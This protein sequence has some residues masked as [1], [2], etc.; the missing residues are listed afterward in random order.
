MTDGNLTD[1]M[2]QSAKILWGITF[3]VAIVITAVVTYAIT[4]STSED[5]GDL[6]W[7]A[8]ATVALDQRL[9]LLEERSDNAAA[10]AELAEQI[11]LQAEVVAELAEQLEADKLVAEESVPEVS[12]EKTPSPD[13]VYP[14]IFGS[15][16]EVD[17]LLLPLLFMMALSG[18]VE[19]PY[20]GPSAPDYD[21]GCSCCSDCWY[22]SGDYCDYDIYDDEPYY[23]DYEYEY[24]EYEEPYLPLDDVMSSDYPSPS[25]EDLAFFME[26]LEEL[27]G[28]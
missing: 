25:E 7:Q 9:S 16:P 8:T 28:S 21:Y 17:E 11:N 3:V 23:D 22:D 10:I 14:D 5:D 26:L 18:A 19:E 12:E 4:S 20:Y 24:E 2:R 13:D 6:V 1:T 15:T 27:F